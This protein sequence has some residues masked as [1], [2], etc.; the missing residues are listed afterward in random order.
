[1]P[2]SIPL[3]TK[4]KCFSFL[5]GLHLIVFIRQ[6]KCEEFIAHFHHSWADQWHRMI[7]CIR[8]MCNCIERDKEKF[9]FKY[10][11]INSAA[12]GLFHSKLSHL[13]PDKGERRGIFWVP[14]NATPIF[15]M[16][17]KLAKGKRAIS[18]RWSELTGR[19]KAKLAANQAYCTDRCIDSTNKRLWEGKCHNADHVAKWKE[20]WRP[21]RLCRGGKL[22]VIE[23]ISALEG[24]VNVDETNDAIDMKSNG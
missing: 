21:R 16:N 18:D 19:F 3:D 4:R 20:N 24:V 14:R 7:Y 9:R 10:I 11:L 5:S 13:F 2:E 8:W 6:D 1:M 17:H 15:R 22:D 12:G 23:Y